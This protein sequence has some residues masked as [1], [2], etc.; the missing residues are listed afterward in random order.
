MMEFIHAVS[1][2][3]TEEIATSAVANGNQL[4]L[5]ELFSKFSMDTIAACAFGVEA[6][7]FDKG[8][9]SAFVKNASG[10]FTRLLFLV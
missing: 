3:L 4:E 7:S 5:K 9:E 10:I 6:G 1:R 8:G 2:R